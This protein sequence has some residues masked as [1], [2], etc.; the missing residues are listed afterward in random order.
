MLYVFSP[1]EN[2][3]A[4]LKPD[5]TRSTGPATTSRAFL[6]AAFPAEFDREPTEG[7]PYWDAVH[8]EVLNGENTF[9]FTVPADRAD[10]AYVAEGNL[11]AFK[12]LDS[13]WQFFE[14][15]RLADIHGDGLTRTAFCE[16]IFYELLDDIVTDKRPSGSAVAALSGMLENTRWQV[17]I[18]DDLGSASASAYYISALEAVQKVANAWKGELRWRCVIAGGVITRYVDLRTMIG[19]D[20]GKQFV[21]SKDILS[22]EREVD[23]SS[24]VTALYGRGKGIELESGSYGRRLTFA[25][26]VAA[27]KPA[28]QEWIGDDDALARWGRPGGRHRFDVFTDE[29]ETVPEVL[30]EKTRAELAK[31]TTPRVTYRL[32][33]VSLEQLTGYEHEQV[34]KGDLVRVIDREFKPELVVSARVIDIERDP[35]NPDNTKVVLGSFAPTIIDATINTRRRVEDMANK[36]YNTKWLDGVIDV[37]QN[38]IENSQAYIWETPQGTLHMNAP[39]YEQA[40]EA[41]LLGGGRFAIANQKDGQGSWN[42]RT[43]GDGSG[44]TG[45]LI[46]AGQIRAEF[47]Q[48]GSATT[49]EAGYD[50]TKGSMGVDADCVGLWHFDGSLNSHKGVSA[51]GDE[52]FDT[53]CFGQAVRVG[54]G[55]LKIPTAGMSASAGTITVRVHNLAASINNSVILSLLKPD[56]ESMALEVE[57][58]NLF[59]SRIRVN[60][61]GENS[62]GSFN[63]A[64]EKYALTAWDTISIAWTSSILSLTINDQEVLHEGDINFA[65]ALGSYFYVGSDK[66]GNHTI[67]TLVDELRIDKAYRDADTRIA[68]HKAGVPFYTSEDMKQWPG[69]MRAET[70]GLKVYDSENALR[71]LVGSWLKDAIRK[72]GIKIIDGE[73]YSSIVRSGAEDAT[74]YIQF[75]PPNV[76]EIYNN[77]VI[78]LRLDASSGGEIFMYKDG[79]L[80][81]KIS[82]NTTNGDL[83]LM[84]AGSSNKVV[85]AGNLYVVG[86]LSCTGSKPAMQ[87]TENYGLR[88]MYATEAPEIIYYDRGRAQL[89]N[90]EATVKLDPIYL[91]CIEPD[92]E[93]TP[94]L[95]KTEVYGL[96][97]DIRVIEWGD[98]YFKVKECNGG[99][100]NRKFGWW[101]EAIRSGY[102][103]FRLME[104]T[105]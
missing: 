71:V 5:F 99:T 58:D 38:A 68:W 30:L 78:Q 92:T 10:A 46:N 6:M 14:I 76:L 75:K 47:I 2:L 11:V 44:F 43:F 89:V 98:N 61:S 84:A 60:Y 40:T 4:L 62:G 94:W 45:D 51:I 102:A 59:P 63:T 9:T 67:N 101:H 23:S 37:L 19:S 96:G 3:I 42:W 95:F 34:R 66:D 65:S 90:G 56:N 91:E 72:Y 33:V 82:T 15:K 100:S 39:S 32:D 77:S 74:T 57:I 28:G 85:S 88:Y 64:V 18:V 8:R 21:Y 69:Y 13:Y 17:G 16:H 87:T 103:G 70:D 48:V 104:V 29:E 54:E 20:T 22:V 97:E 52:N 73:I 105:D 26:V 79:E 31:R 53:G 24:V 25:N 80:A 93:L 49:F 27:D 55:V 35:D 81:G 86:N 36:P 50:P 12:D 7:C 41:M 1:D 83:Y